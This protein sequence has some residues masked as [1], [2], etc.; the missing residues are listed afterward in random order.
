MRHGW[1]AL[2][3]LFP[4]VMACA[5]PGDG[6]SLAEVPELL[7]ARAAAVAPSWTR[8]SEGIESYTTRVAF[9]A[10]FSGVMYASGTRLFTSWN[11]GEG[12]FGR[13][14]SQHNIP[15]LELT[16]DPNR[17]GRVYGE[18]HGEPFVTENAGLSWTRLA[19]TSA[20][21]LAVAPGSSSVLFGELASALHKSVDRG[22]SWTPVAV[23][24]GLCCGRVVAVSSSELYV[25]NQ[26]GGQVHHSYDGG[27]SWAISTDATLPSLHD[28]AVD[29]RSPNVVYAVGD[30]DAAVPSRA[31]LAKSIDGGRTWTRPSAR[32]ASEPLSSV[33]VSPVD[34]RVYVT[35]ATSSPELRYEVLVS[36]DGGVNFVSAN[37][38]LEGQAFNG[39]VVPHPSQRCVA[40]IATNGGVYRTTNAGG[41]CR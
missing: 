19:P 22:G 9:D 6:E 13:E 33:S 32:F 35:R 41:T 3:A 23:P 18:W 28:F 21:V 15:F 14:S 40:A 27:T 11:Y 12:W 17:G 10:R 4:C 37:L 31:G 5:E 29:R 30:Y 39:H 20:V 38:G 8:K 36:S 1:S 2:Y 24:N 26:F 25:S 7:E 16:P 34:G